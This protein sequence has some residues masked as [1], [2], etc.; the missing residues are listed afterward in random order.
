MFVLTLHQKLLE[1]EELPLISLALFIISY[2]FEQLIKK[3]LL[4]GV[5]SP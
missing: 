1:G 2:A 3:D 5:V 4:S